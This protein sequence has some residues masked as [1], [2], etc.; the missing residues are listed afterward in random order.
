VDTQFQNFKHF[1]EETI[2]IISLDLEA[3]EQIAESGNSSTTTTQTT[4]RPGD[5]HLFTPESPKVSRCTIPIAMVCFSV[6]DMFGQWVNEFHDDDFAHSS[7]A[8]FERLASKEDLK[9]EKA[10]KIFKEAFRHGIVHSFFARQGFSITY[11]FFQGNALFM[12]LHGQYATLDV[13]YLLSVVRSGMAT[14]KEALVDA[15]SELTQAI[16]KGH[17][18]WLERQK[19][20][21]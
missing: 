11:P 18:R 10:K 5:E 19:S 21:L 1:V 2:E 8:F 7:S 9:N 15:D 12:N 17:K 14:L 4:I 16:I 6:I 3:M 13:K 20:L